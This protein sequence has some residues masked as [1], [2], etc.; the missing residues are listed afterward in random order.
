M[1]RR[2]ALS[3]ILGGLLC[4]RVSAFESEFPM[5]DTPL[6]L[7]GMDFTALQGWVDLPEAKEW[8]DETVPRPYFQSYS[9]LQGTGE[10][11]Q[12]CLWKAYEKVTKKPFEPHYQKIGD[13][14]GQGFT[15]GAEVLSTF[16]IAAGQR[17]EWRG[18]F[19][20]E[21]TYAGSRIEVGKG[22]I[23]TGD[24]SSGAWAAEFL[25]TY[26]V[27]LRKSY[28]SIDLSNYDPD[29]ARQWGHWRSSGVPTELESVAREHPIKTTARVT[30]WEEYCDAISN[31]Y[32]VAICSNVGFDDTLD[33]EGFLRR[34]GTW[35]HCMLGWGVDSKSSRQGGC[36][37]NSWGRNWLSGPQHK[38]GTP[39]G[40][41]WAD[42]DVIDAMLKQGDSY[43]LSGFIGF[44]SGT[45]VL[46]YDLI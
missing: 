33:R 11:K 32:P 37:A 13:C 34:Q 1:N 42:A 7:Q 26:G 22:K 10:N 36:I 5:S 14:V 25:R 27:V 18:K 21:V 24:G 40:C 19:S 16:E 2:D 6:I 20:T 29:L 15:L 28:G 9:G 46:D 41:F 8:Y 30:N 35:Y 43:A 39:A 3:I 45:H 12:V 38:L 17:E 31:G 23:K 44:P 4:S